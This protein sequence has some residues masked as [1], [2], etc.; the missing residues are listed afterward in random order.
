MDEGKFWTGVVVTIAVLILSLVGSCQLST[1]SQNEQI[2]KA[3]TCE[4]AF[5]IRHNGSGDTRDL[6]A[7]LRTACGK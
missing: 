2:L 3:D 5:L 6:A 7:T 1:L 4:K